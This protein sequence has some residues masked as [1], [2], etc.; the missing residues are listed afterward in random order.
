MTNYKE[1]IIS[2]TKKE[3]KTWHERSYDQKIEEIIHIDDNNNNNNNNNVSLRQREFN[4]NAEYVPHYQIKPHSLTTEWVS[5][6][7]RKFFVVDFGGNMDRRYSEVNKKNHELRVNIVTGTAHGP[8]TEL[9]LPSAVGHPWHCLPV[10][11]L[12]RAEF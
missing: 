3:I 5:T 2:Q 1:S 12:E 8:L 10:G 4:I 11:Y 9:A 6:T 7:R